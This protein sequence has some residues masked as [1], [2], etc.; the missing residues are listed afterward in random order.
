[1]LLA[2]C[3]VDEVVG[4]VSLTCAL[5]A[6]ETS[7]GAVAL[8]VALEM[9]ISL[10]D[11]SDQMPFYPLIKVCRSIWY[12]TELFKGLPRLTEALDAAFMQV[13]SNHADLQETTLGSMCFCRLGPAERRSLFS[14]APSRATVTTNHIGY[15][16]T[17]L[18]RI[19]VSA[20]SVI[21]SAIN[22]LT[23]GT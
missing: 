1:L 17:K 23:S 16:Q 14:T 22:D 7:V 2:I 5:L 21:L 4:A 15:I 11:L 3:M 19:R 6:D 18:F 13:L 10:S 8:V 12:L 9:M 20:E